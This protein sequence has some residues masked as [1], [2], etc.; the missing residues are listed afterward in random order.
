MLKVVT[1]FSGGGGVEAGLKD[2]FGEFEGYAVEFN[3]RNPKH[4]S[5]IADCYQK[6]FPTH[7]LFRKTI[8]DMAA[9]NF[10]ELP[11]NP[12]ILWA[13]PECVY[14][15]QLRSHQQTDKDE[16]DFQALYAMQAIYRLQPR[17]FILENVPNYRNS[18]AFQLLVL[19]NLR[20]MG[21][22]YQFKVVRTLTHQSRDRLILWATKDELLPPPQDAI[23]GGWWWAISDLVEDLPDI[24]LSKRYQNLLPVESPTWMNLV[25]KGSHRP[26]PGNK[27][28]PTVT[29]ARFTDSKGANR[30][31][32]AAIALPDGR[33]KQVSMECIKRL[34]GFP[35]W[36]QLPKK[37]AIAGSI[38]GN[39]VPPAFI[40]EWLSKARPFFGVS[41]NPVYHDTCFWDTPLKQDGIGSVTFDYAKRRYLFVYKEKRRGEWKRKSK[42]IKQ[43][44]APIVQQAR[45]QGK[46]V[47]EILEII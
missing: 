15:S 35:D 12:D 22:L 4:S 32:F 28:C 3:P 37:T 33:V 38:L 16:E 36:Y 18:Q 31:R 39:S 1:L 43:E 6:N 29:K 21:Y 30:N 23:L 19:Q 44:L 7:H 9:T 14:S 26:T 8:E 2:I 27:P 34:Q 13:S 41:Q 46:D 17:H 47:K 40:K 10:M 5:A 45:S 20:H 25:G 42:H 24:A 11:Q